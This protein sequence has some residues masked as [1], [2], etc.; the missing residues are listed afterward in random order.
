VPLTSMSDFVTRLVI[1]VYGSTLALSEKQYAPLKLLLEKLSAFFA[2]QV[3]LLTGGG[4][5]A[6]QQAAEIGKALGLSVGCNFLEIQDQ[7]LTGSKDF[8]QTFQQSARHFRQRWF[9]IS[10]FQLF[11]IGG[12]GTLE[13]IGLTLTDMKLSVTEKGPLVFFGRSSEDLYWSKL[14]EQL[15]VI[16]EE[17]RGPAWL[18]T[19]VLMTDDPDEVIS[20]YERV[21]ELGLRESPHTNR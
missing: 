20:F 3:A 18:S 10:S 16:V 4:P 5:G 12:L 9:D 7:H 8:Y 14:R 15:N 21:L 2:G 6:M 17:K 13:E 19:H 1:A 11:C